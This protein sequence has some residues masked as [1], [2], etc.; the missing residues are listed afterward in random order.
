MKQ[1]PEFY[2]D[3]YIDTMVKSLETAFERIFDEMNLRKQKA[4]DAT[5]DIIKM[6]YVSEGVGL[7]QACLIIQDQLIKDGLM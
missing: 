2:A 6:Q 3:Y 5:A 4:D 1:I 7:G